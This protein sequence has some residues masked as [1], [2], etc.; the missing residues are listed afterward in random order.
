MK[1][2]TISKIALGLFL[3]YLVGIGYIFLFIGIIVIGVKTDFVL[4]LIWFIL[5]IIWILSCLW[6]LTP[7][8]DIEKSKKGCD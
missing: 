6:I 5:L 3:F 4:F 8:E 2:E 7:K 1:E